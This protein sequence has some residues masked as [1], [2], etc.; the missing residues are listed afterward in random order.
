M[1]N[2][3]LTGA[4]KITTVVFYSRVEGS[5]TSLGCFSFPK[6][7]ENFWTGLRTQDES[8]R[9]LLHDPC[10]NDQFMTWQCHKSLPTDLSWIATR[11][12]H[13]S[14]TVN[15]CWFVNDDIKSIQAL[16]H[17]TVTSLS[18]LQHTLVYVL[19]DVDSGTTY[20]VTAYHVHAGITKKHWRTTVVNTIQLLIN[21]P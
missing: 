11:T 12:Q 14:S 17:I 15:F 8:C 7:G 10:T 13:I 1:N 20:C 3:V 18:Q 6:P 4:P 5:T 9:K 16:V 19:Y 21:F 2:H